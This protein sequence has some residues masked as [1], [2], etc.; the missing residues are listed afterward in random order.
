MNFNIGAG[1]EAMA[2]ASHCVIIFSCGIIAIF[3]VSQ[4]VIWKGSPKYCM[5]LMY[6]AGVYRPN[7]YDLVLYANLKRYIIRNYGGKISV[8]GNELS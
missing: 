2:P 6:V 8:S 1:L 3:F 5:T 4:G 7:F